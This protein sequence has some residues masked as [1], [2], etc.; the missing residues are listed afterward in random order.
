MQVNKLANL[1]AMLVWNY[2]RLTNPLTS[3][4][5][6]ATSIVKNYN[7]PTD[8]GHR[9][10]CRATSVAK[11]Q[12]LHPVMNDPAIQ[13]TKCQKSKLSANQTISNAENRR[14]WENFQLQVLAVFDT[15]ASLRSILKGLLVILWNRIVS[16][17]AWYFIRLPQHWV[18][19]VM[20]CWSKVV[21][22]RLRIVDCGS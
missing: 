13:R 12:W 9:V 4:E 19:S 14:V 1:E 3:G 10:K 8:R 17:R 18:N 2:D 21:D 7:G 11:N 15:R 16:N 22:H 5:W 20:D 6:R